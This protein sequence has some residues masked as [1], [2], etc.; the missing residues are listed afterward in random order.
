MK[1]NRV[2]AII[3]NVNCYGDLRDLTAHR[4]LATLP[5]DCKYRLIDFQLSNIINANIQALFLLMNHDDM[6]SVFDHINGGKE[7][8]LDSLRNKFIM[9]F[10]KKNNDGE[11]EQDF[12]SHVIDYL[13][14][15]SSEIT[16]IMGSKMLCNI[17][18]K[19]IIKIHKQNNCNMTVVYKRVTSENISDDNLLINL[20][21]DKNISICNNSKDE[22]EPTE[23]YNLCMDIFIV[24]TQWLIEILENY[25]KK[26]ESIIKLLREKIGNEACMS[27]EYTGY[28]SNIY[29][30]PSYYRANMDMLQPSKFNSLLYS[31][32]KIYTKLA[33]EVPTHYA[34]NSVVNNSHF[35]SGSIVDGTVVDSLIARRC[36]ISEAAVIEHS[37]IMASVN[38]K[39]NAYIK[40]AIL[41]KNV[42]VDEGVRI[43]GDDNNPIVIKKDSHITNDI[44]DRRIV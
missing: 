34:Q 12:V 18:L 24:R 21:S 16:L 28:L 1:T 4:P 13:R 15:S 26:I 35:A 6:Q 20:E 36:R 9:H 37:I 23:K 27:Y 32:Q 40:N 31:N 2:S 43:I 22:L 39:K 14:K 25:D 10:N 17:D 11:Y 44:V 38:I 8:G 42:I 30:I 19:S 5:F 41:D 7:W 3:D 33:N 29:D